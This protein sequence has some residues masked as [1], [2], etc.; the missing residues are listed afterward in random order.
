MKE[1]KWNVPYSDTA[2]VLSAGSQRQKKVAELIQTELAQ[3]LCSRVNDTRLRRVNIVGVKLSSDLSNATVIVSTYAKEDRESIMTALQKAT[4]HLRC[5][6]AEVHYGRRTPR[7]H[8]LYDKAQDK[9]AT[10]SALIDQ[11]TE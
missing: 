1:L 7:L 8:F 5:L 9:V 10:L 11:I 6:L 2:D 4:G 3:I